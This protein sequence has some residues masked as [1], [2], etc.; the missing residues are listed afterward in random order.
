MNKTGALTIIILALL[1]SSLMVACVS[2]STTE[3]FTVAQATKRY[4]FELPQ[5]AIF[6]GSL[7]T[8]GPVRVWVND[9]N[10]TQLVNLGLVD[11]TGQINFVATHQGNY[12]INFENNLANTVEVTFTYQTDPELENSSAFPVALLPIIAI[13]IAAVCIVLV[14]VIR[15]KFKDEP[16][17]NRKQHRK[18]SHWV[19]VDWHCLRGGYEALGYSVVFRCTLPVVHI[20]FLTDLFPHRIFS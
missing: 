15:R 8:T 18:S 16:A 17:D 6:N 3:T 14:I 12:Y 4:T 2:A 1:G 13:V 10:G 9:A 11:A 20:L 19:I 5:G 7:S